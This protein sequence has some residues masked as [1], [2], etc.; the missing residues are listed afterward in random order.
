MA[1]RRSS[2]THRR[3]RDCPRMRPPPRR[4][5]SSSAASC[6]A[7]ARRAARPASTSAGRAAVA[8]HHRHQGRGLGGAQA[9]TEPPAGVGAPGRET[10][11]E[12][13]DRPG[14]LVRVEDHGATLALPRARVSGSGRARSPGDAAAAA[15]AVGDR[16]DRPDQHGADPV[17]AAGRPP[18]PRTAARAPRRPSPGSGPGRGAW[19]SGR[20]RGRRPRPR[21][22]RRRARRGRRPGS[23]RSTRTR[24]VGERA[25]PRPRSASYSSVISPTISSSRSSMV[26]RPAVPPYSSTTTAMCWR[27]GLHLAQ[28]RVDRLG[29]GHVERRPHHR[30]DALGGLRRRGASKTRRTDVL[31]VGEA[32]DVVEVLAD[33]RDPGEAAAQEQRHRLAQVL[34]ALDV[35]HVGAR[36]HHLAHDGVA[37]LEDRVDHLPLA[38]LDHRGRLG[39]VDQLAQLGLGR[40]RAL[41]EAAARGDRVAD[42]DQQ[43][44][45]RAED[46]GRRRED[47]RRPTRARPARRAGGRGCA[48]P[49]PMTTNEHHE[50]HADRGQHASASRSPS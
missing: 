29:V 20:R 34:V 33:H 26:T 31:E 38:G 16:E 41:A 14:R 21:R 8:R 1:E 45:D 9:A 49:T 35:D 40:E 2:S 37:E 39:E 10:V 36:H 17:A 12:V 30:V 42:Q 5:R 15:G 47:R 22:R 27:V 28:Q 18:R 6:C 4:T 11:E 7:C 50:H 32:D 43:P 44:R 19:P 13:G 23:A 24:A 3:A 46:P 48:G 25:R